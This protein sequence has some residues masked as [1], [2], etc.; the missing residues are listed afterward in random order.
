MLPTFYIPHGGGP[1]FFMDWDP[2]DEWTRMRDFLSGFISELPEQPS[3]LL[4]ISAHWEEEEVTVS[5]GEKPGL[6]Y[7]YYH[8]PPH[9][10]QLTWSAK[11]DPELAGRIQELLSNAGIENRCDQQR[12]FDHG[13]FIPLKLALPQA[14][15]RT[16]VVS[17]QCDLNPEFH[18][19]LGKALAPLRREKVLIIGS[20]MSYHNLGSM[21]SGRNSPES[22]EF[23]IWL[24]DTVEGEPQRRKDLLCNWKQAPNARKS[25]PRE[26]HLA[27]LFVACGAAEKEHGKQVFSDRVLGAQVSAFRF[28]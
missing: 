27:P 21:L 22:K 12:G 15:I 25:H 24:T 20:G 18:L 23:D 5:A 13:V 26:E 9:T 28:G 10:Y 4:I 7:D 1:C 8:F 6:I 3:R 11:G 17:L 2:P 19:Q 14:D 16:V